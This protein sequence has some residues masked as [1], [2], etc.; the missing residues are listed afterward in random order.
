LFLR[1][2]PDGAASFVVDARS[3]RLIEEFLKK[4]FRALT[5]GTEKD[6]FFD[7]V[8]ETNADSVVSSIF[9]IAKEA[10]K[11]PLAIFT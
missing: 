1:T 9:V 4:T 8:I 11:I 3:A 7:E 6:Y 5:K 2:D 10:T